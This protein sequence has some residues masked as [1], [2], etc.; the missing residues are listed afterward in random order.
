V[1]YEVRFTE[2]A[3]AFM[4]AKSSLETAEATARSE[5]ADLMDNGLADPRELILHVFEV[6][7][8][9]LICHGTAYGII[10]D[11]CTYEEIGEPLK[12]G[13]LA[14]K[15]IMMPRGDSE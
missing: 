12:E 3:A 8:Q 15:K 9:D 11:T 5:M 13:P 1:S 7:D 10:V 14:G 2:M 4:K 6:G